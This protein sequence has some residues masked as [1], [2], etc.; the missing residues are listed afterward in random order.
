MTDAQGRTTTTTLVLSI[1]RTPFD[2]DPDANL[3]S[4]ITHLVPITCDRCRDQERKWSVAARSAMV[5]Q[6]DGV[7]LRS[8]M[9]PDHVP[10]SLHDAATGALLCDELATRKSVV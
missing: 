8:R 3:C 2:D 10:A 6:S 4:G 1:D 9:I 5:R 7:L